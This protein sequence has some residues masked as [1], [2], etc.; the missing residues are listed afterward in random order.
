MEFPINL[1]RIFTSFEY[2][3]LSVLIDEVG[4]EMIDDSVNRP[5]DTIVGTPP[6]IV[7]P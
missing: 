6:E 4:V 5:G 2:R 3:N 1:S 7:S